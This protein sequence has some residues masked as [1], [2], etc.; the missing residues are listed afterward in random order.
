MMAVGGR[1]PRALKR[2]FGVARVEHGFAWLLLR[3]NANGKESEA[4]K[5]LHSS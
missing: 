3:S 4:E 2:L 5:D 1:Q